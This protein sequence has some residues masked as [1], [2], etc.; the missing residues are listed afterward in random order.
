[1]HG[2]PDLPQG[3]AAGV[4]VAAVGLGATALLAAVAGG[5]SWSLGSF[6]AAGAAAHLVASLPVWLVLLVHEVRAAQARAAALEARRL[7]ALAREGRRAI[8]AEAGD[9]GGGVLH[10]EAA[11]ERTRRVGGA[12]AALATAALELL[13]VWALVTLFPRPGA[14]ATL[15]AAAALC[16]GAFGLLVIGRYAAALARGGAGLEVAAGGRRATSGALLLLVAGLTLAAAHATGQP[17]LDL[18]GHGYVAVSAL[19][20]L[21]ALLLLLLEAYRPRRPGEVARPVF[22]SRL[23]GLISAPGDMARS[24]ARTVDYQFGFALSQTW[25]YRFLERWVAPIAGFALVVLWALSSVVVVAPH[26]R[27]LVRRLGTLREGVLLTP[28]A[29]LKLPWPVDEVVL[30]PHERVQSFMTGDHEVGGLAPGAREPTVLWTER[31]DAE[32]DRPAGR[33]EDADMLVLLARRGAEGE[34]AVNLLATAATVAFRVRDPRAFAASVDDPRA[35]LEALAERELSF[36]LSGSDL[37]ELLVERG[38]VADALR[39]RLQAAADDLGLGVEVTAAYL[40]ELHPPPEVGRSFEA[41]T[42][43]LEE[44]EARILDA[45]AHA[46]RVGPAARAEAARVRD[47]ARVSAR[48]RVALARADADRFA[49]QRLLDRA[50]PG[51]YR[52]HLLLRALAHGTGDARKVVVGRGADVTTDLNLEERISAEQLNLGAGFAEPATGGEGR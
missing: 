2:G 3:H 33:D 41:V 38:P 18:V 31:H 29:S 24:I 17:G 39:A 9:G 19:L 44:R 8:F 52:M 45:V 11:L 13:A 15:P 50:A 48:G 35:L 43:A 36:M 22:D 12:V 10:D 30:V 42:A 20:G 6:V 26:E 40:T 14:G 32:D 47:A 21:E 27:G 1:M 16:G 51:V 28:G 23:L 37:D 46:A 49:A 25:F 34:D 7:E 4:R 5:L